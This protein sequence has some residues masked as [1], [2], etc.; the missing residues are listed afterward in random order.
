MVYDFTMDCRQASC[1]LG[2]KTDETAVSSAK[3]INFKSLLD[4]D[5]ETNFSTA[6]Q[7][8]LNEEQIY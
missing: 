8:F 2:P 3:I 6:T 4:I 5:S 7:N 1:E